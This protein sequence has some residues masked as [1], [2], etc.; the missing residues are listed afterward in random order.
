[1]KYN[2]DMG[3]R[4]TSRGIAAPDFSILHRPQL[5]LIRSDK[6]LHFTGSLAKN[7]SGQENIT[8]LLLNKIIIKK[9]SIR[10]KQYLE[11]RLLFFSKDTFTKDDLNSDT[12]I[13]EV[14][15]N[16][17]TF[18]SKIIPPGRE[19]VIDIGSPAIDRIGQ[20]GSVLGVNRFLIELANPANLAGIITE[21]SAFFTTAI[22]GKTGYLVTFYEGV[23]GFF[24]SRD[25]VQ[26]AFPSSVGKYTWTGL[27]LNVEVGDYIG[28]G[29][30]PGDA[31]YGIDCEAGGVGVRHNQAGLTLPIVNQSFDLY[32][33][34]IMSLEGVGLLETNYLELR[35]LNIPYEDLDETKELHVIL[36]NLSPTEK[37]KGTNGEVVIEVE[38]EPVA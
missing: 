18:R 19:P 23:V 24:S 10:S 27:S 29:L 1:M 26:V 36:K 31:D 2:I 33:D 12:F 21:V 8:G 38:Y 35:D 22:A 32:A 6:D 37:T 34:N 28:I 4:I 7:E 13:G 3:K 5:E 11:Y 15:L 9:I 25:Y 14:D 16:L 17:P 20:Y 30:P